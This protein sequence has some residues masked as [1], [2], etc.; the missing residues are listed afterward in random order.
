MN[1]VEEFCNQPCAE[2]ICSELIGKHKSKVVTCGKYSKRMVDTFHAIK[3]IEL[4]TI[5]N[6][7]VNVPQH[8]LL[9]SCFFGWQT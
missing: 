5:V 4:L 1:R 9:L 3:W 8:D 2:V 7:V 6:I